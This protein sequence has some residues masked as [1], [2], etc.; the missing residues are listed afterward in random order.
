MTLE[1]LPAHLYE[2]FARMGKALS[3]PT[4]LKILNLLCQTERSVD[5]LA[6]KLGHSSANTSAHLKVLQ[7]AQLISRRKE[8]RRVFYRLAGEPALRLWLA[9]RDTGL[10]QL[11]QAREAMNKY[12]SE[13]QVVP[14]LGG[15]ELLAKVKAGDVVLLDLRPS[16]EYD[17]GHLPNARSIPYAELEDRIEELDDHRRVVAYC[18]GPY[19]V[20]AIKGVDE[21]RQHGIDARRL[22]GGVAEWRAAGHDVEVD[23]AP[24][25]G[26]SL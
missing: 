15:Q 22:S 14:D 23:S 17:S 21:L 7:R 12:A 9:L 11:P 4:R 24:R 18:R 8:G 20:A 13:P 10:E 19:C 16:E 6:E 2:Q 26:A 1:N 5:N 25:A 3:D